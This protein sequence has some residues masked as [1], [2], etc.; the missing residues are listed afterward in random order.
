[1]A[2]R[3][4]AAASRG[5][6]PG[7][8]DRFI[9]HMLVGALRVSQC[10]MMF[11]D[12]AGRHREVMLP[13]GA[14]I[15]SLEGTFCY[16]NLEATTPELRTLLRPN[17]ISEELIDRVN[18]YISFPSCGASLHFD[19]RTVWI[20]QLFGRKTWMVGDQPAVDAPHRN[21][22]AP[23]DVESVDYD[24]KKLILPR[25]LTEVVLKPGDWLRVPRAVWHKTHTN[26]GSVS[27]TLAAPS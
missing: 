10:K 22:V 27:V 24:G 15:E 13:S 11:L 2:K 18:A 6:D 4:S 14:D 8:L 16:M 26:V 12:R 19:I 9:D 20:V 5:T 23:P 21:C 1:M 7:V 3:H 25:K 17:Q